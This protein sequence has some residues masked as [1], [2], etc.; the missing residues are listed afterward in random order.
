M[1]LE[2]ALL[3]PALE[4]AIRIIREAP[5]D[6]VVV[7]TPLR[8]YLRFGRLPPPARH[9]VR[10]VLEADASLRG[11][12]AGATDEQT[13]G[14]AGWL[15]LSRPVGWQDEFAALVAARVD[16]GDDERE[17]SARRRLRRAEQ[18]IAALEER[19][20]RHAEEAATLRAE[21]DRRSAA[22]EERS[23]EVDR[24]RSLADEA[25]EARTRAVRE[26]KATERR[27]NERVAELRAAA[28]SSAAFPSS[29]PPPDPG[30]DAGRAEAGRAEADGARLDRAVAAVDELRRMWGEL[31]AALDDVVAVLA[32]LTGRRVETST[33]PVS[34][35]VGEAGGA[36][37]GG[38]ARRRPTRLVRGLLDGTTEALAWLAG[39]PDALLLVDGYNA[40]MGAWPDLTVAEQRDAL[41]AVAGR[42][43]Q[44]TGARL[45]LVFDG[46]DEGPASAVRSAVG[47]SVRVRFTA[48]GVEADDELLAMVDRTTAAVVVVVSDDRRV[49]DGAARRGANVARPAALLS[50]GR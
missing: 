50:L 6:A 20:A 13:V 24:W 7:P 37:R 33:E 12:V 40:T 25:T 17:R 48:R 2:L 18:A 23:S 39:R 14:R 15:W 29:P 26:L 28:S 16:A 43:Q 32:E 22:L 5:A 1:D 47:S 30:P 4:A 42:V 34:N 9:A 41:E 46:D 31:G 10:S 11:S 49:Q 19:A 3:G 21:L 35:G 38:T 45:V 36:G 27:L 8:P 44:R